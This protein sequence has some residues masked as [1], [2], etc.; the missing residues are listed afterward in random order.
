MPLRSWT[1]RLP[2]RPAARPTRNCDSSATGE[3]APGS[4]VHTGRFSPVTIGFWLGG[5][6]MGT[7]GCLLGALMPY[8]HPVAVAISVLWWGLY[9]G[10]FGA[11]VGALVGVLTDRAPPRPAVRRE[12]A[13]EVTTKLGL[14]S[15]AAQ[16]GS[17]AMCE[18]RGQRGLPGPQRERERP[19][20]P[21]D[22]F[23]PDEVQKG[24]GTKRE[25]Q[26]REGD[27]QPVPRSGR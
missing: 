9:F 13:E 3:R 20:S 6:G 26:K 17:P 5:A 8:R 27:S 21:F 16:A 7:G 24:R 12:R 1:H 11:S 25:R 14:D 4:L 19:A 23:E 15:R 18:P 2:A 22:K 10:C